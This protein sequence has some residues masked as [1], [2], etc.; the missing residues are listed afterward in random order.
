MDWVVG[1]RR[2][3]QQYKNRRKKHS[4][5]AYGGWWED[6]TGIRNDN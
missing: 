6:K 1:I 5:L 4:F 2:G 3:P